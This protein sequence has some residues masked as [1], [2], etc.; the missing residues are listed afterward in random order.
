LTTPRPA[1]RNASSFGWSAPIAMAI[2]AVVAQLFI[3]DR[4]FGLLDEG[5]MLSLA[6]DIRRGS[7]LY[8]DVY[9]DNP[10]P[11]SFYLLAG[12]FSIVGAS[13]WASRV[14][15]V[16][17]FA[18]T[19]GCAVRIATTV[20]PRLGVLAVAI[21]L[22]VYRIWAFPHW[23]LYSYSSV[24][25][26]MI[27]AATAVVLRARDRPR[28]LLVAGM[29]LGVGI[30]SK[31]D[32]G[33]TVA[34]MLTLFL[35]LRPV[36]LPE[37]EESPVRLGLGTAKWL[38]AG[39]AIVVVP[40]LLG[41]AIVGALPALIEQTVLV[42]LQGA[43][44][45]TYPGLP[46]LAPLF[47]QDPALRDGIGSY[48]P[49]ILLTLRWESIAASW[50]FR[51][52]ARWDVA[53]KLTYY[54]PIVVWL[55][56][57]L[58]WSRAVWR[59][60][61]TDSDPEPIAR[62]LLLLAWAGGYLLCLKPPID[63]VH[64]MMIYPPVLVIG[65]VLVADAWPRVVVPVRVLVGA[66]VTVVLVALSVVSLH[67][68]AELRA[69]FPYYV[70]DARGGFWTEERHG[71]IIRDV[72]DYVDANAA[73][74]TPVPVYPMLPGFGFLAGRETA[75]GFHV[76]WPFQAPDRD[77]RIIA[78]LERRDVDTIIYSL[79]QYAHLGSFRDNAP[80]LFAY[81]VE[82]YDL[83]ATFSRERWG[84]L[85]TA[86]ARRPAVASP[87]SEFTTKLSG[88]HAVRWPFADVVA[89]DVRA[90][91]TTEDVRL[92]LRVPLQPA[93]LDFEYGINPDR[94]LALLDGPFEFAIDVEGERVFA[95]SLDPSRNLGDRR[96]APGSIDLV[97]WTGRDVTVAL[98]VTGP[99]SLVGD[100]D[101]TGFANVR[102]T[103]TPAATRPAP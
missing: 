3:Y 71:P 72:L 51:E 86:L 7:V 5:Y 53:L 83:V 85:L 59:I 25:V 20:L 42:P 50:A 70:A 78:D 68:G 57:A 67:L 26:A 61:R 89:V 63:W 30:L 56:G 35:A 22:L 98:H 37:D 99:E 84:P 92:P 45:G 46:P 65:A 36:L 87:W 77:E 23:Q 21:L 24:A 73:P 52:T 100:P 76:I 48:F 2:V 13:V 34:A 8:R 18:L 40:T 31:Q 9:V 88:G 15:A 66:A 103:D 39:G 17:L 69:T 79:S 94:W 75:A 14:L 16:A 90:A 32:Y 102:V 82:H 93:T 44:S 29:L 1:T 54:A 81:L 101:L 60:R 58:V 41:F 10:L 33:L 6:E 11:A 95:A 62:R 91:G 47:A 55:V 49:A 28:A 19:V 74:G 12:W 43:S 80:R 38:V 96:W 64:L 97:P 4:W 27:T